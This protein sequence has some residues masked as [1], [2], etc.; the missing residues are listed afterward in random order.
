M[1]FNYVA[2]LYLNPSMYIKAKT[3]SL[4][5]HEIFKNRI[6]MTLDTQLQIRYL[7]IVK[8]FN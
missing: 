8:Q 6:A 4:T 3:H 7:T 2:K 1:E 5:D